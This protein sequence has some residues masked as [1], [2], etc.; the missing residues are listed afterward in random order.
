MCCMCYGHIG[1]HTMDRHIGQSSL[2]LDGHLHQSTID[3]CLPKFSSPMSSKIWQCE[4]PTH[5]QST[6]TTQKTFGT[7]IALYS[8]NVLWWVKF[9]AWAHCP[10]HVHCD[11]N[12]PVK[13][14]VLA[15][16]L[17]VLWH[18]IKEVNVPP[19]SQNPCAICA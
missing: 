4:S 11:E 18:S 16:K 8:S 7:H 5:C 15:V 6:A 17:C 2:A 10:L 14:H 13:L 1:T 12:A 19:L 3:P 9:D